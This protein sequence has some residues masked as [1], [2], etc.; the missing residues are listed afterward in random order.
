MFFFHVRTSFTLPQSLYELLSIVSTFSSRKEIQMH[1]S[2]LPFNSC[3]IC[4]FVKADGSARQEFGKPD[5]TQYYIFQC[6]RFSIIIH[7]SQ[8]CRQEFWP[9][10]YI[11]KYL[12]L[13]ITQYYIFQCTGFPIIIHYSQQTHSTDPAL[14]CWLGR[15]LTHGSVLKKEE[16]WC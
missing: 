6:S 11:V 9:G 5:I 16:K 13:D 12:V 2:R 1:D 4:E 14:K 7:K 15:L 10:Y 3:K 8:Y